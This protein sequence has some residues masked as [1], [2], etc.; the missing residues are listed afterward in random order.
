MSDDEIAKHFADLTPQGQ[1]DLLANMALHLCD[2]ATTYELWDMATSVAVRMD[3]EQCAFFSALGFVIRN[4]ELDA[5]A[6]TSPS[7]PAPTQ[8]PPEPQ[9]R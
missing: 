2:G 5:G 9:P 1:A 8:S 4:R 7:S 3:L 6:E